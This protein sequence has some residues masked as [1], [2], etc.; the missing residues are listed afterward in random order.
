[1]ECRAGML[2]AGGEALPV[3]FT[4][5]ADKQRVDLTL[6]PARDEAWRLT[7]ARAS[8][9]WTL[10]L[11]LRAARL[12]RIAPWLPQTAP[13]PSIG[14]ADGVVSFAGTAARPASV[15][16]KLT[17]TDLAFADSAGLN[18]G[19]KLAGSLTLTGRAAVRGMSFTASAVWEQGEL[20]WS[21]FY[22]ANGGHR[23]DATGLWSGTR[24]SVDDAR[25]AL[26]GVG[27]VRGSAQWDPAGGI[28][29]LQVRGTALRAAAAYEL[30]GKPLLAGTALG[31]L[32]ASGTADFAL[33]LVAGRL[34]S[35]ELVLHD[36][37]VADRQGRFSLSGV[38]AVLPWHA[39]QP[40]EARIALAGGALFGLPIGAFSAPIAVR[41]A[42]IEVPQVSVPIADGRLQIE[43]F[44]IG[45]VAGDWRWRFRGVLLPVSMESMTRA[46]GLP[47][48]RGTLSASVPDVSFE[49]GRIDVAGALGIGVFDGYVS[50]SDLVLADVLTRAP[51]LSANVEMR[52]LDLGL[53]TS[54]F[55]FG[56]MQGRIDAEVRGLELS[57]WK[58][59][60]FDARIA[61]SPGDYPRRISQQAV[62]NISALGGAGA[63]A[64][65]QRS[66]LRV[67][68]EFRYDKLGL[69]CRLEK[70]VCQMGGVES[71]PQGY[72]IVKGGGIPSITVTGYNRFVGWE[73]LLERLKRVTQENVTPIV[74]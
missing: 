55:K 74:R 25:L 60:A 32:S 70:G 45:R 50:I 64:A 44:H 59:V 57:A 38:E 21:P 49:R 2:T 39:E 41:G 53:V 6:T 56:S 54:T 13:R 65:I 47:A 40:R 36:L 48:M 16:A 19:E 42:D 27:E 43:D 62:A 46:F 34:Q 14:I 51:R 52:G 35:A 11:E 71:T 22:L 20:F 68:E 37:A 17:L 63:A 69:S 61:S 72:V 4:Y 5:L 28:D 73:E 7:A 15:D 18:A 33:A 3:R 24:L 66:V 67:F 9:G 1:V 26:A 31:D 30:V 8:T 58:P 23:L 12:A 10:A 29:R